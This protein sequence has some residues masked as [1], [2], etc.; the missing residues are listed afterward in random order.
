MKIFL[1]IYLIVSFS[2]IGFA[3]VSQN[4]SLLTAECIKSEDVCKTQQ[5]V[6]YK[7]INGE[8]VGNDVLLTVKTDDLRFDLGGNF[9]YQDKYV[10]TS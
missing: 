4:K 1:F 8:Y 6:K 2:L 10:I 5:I 7:F 9:I 3:Q